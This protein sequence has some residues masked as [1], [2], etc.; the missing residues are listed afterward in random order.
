MLDATRKQAAADAAA[1]VAGIDIDDVK[2]GVEGH[3]G[4]AR[5]AADGEADDDAIVERDKDR[6]IGRTVVQPDA[7]PELPSIG[8]GEGLERPGGKDAGIGRLPGRRVDRRDSIDIIR[9]SRTN[10]AAFRM[11]KE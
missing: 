9:A 4:I 7:G 10:H 11:R 2:L 1:P 5:R 8:D 3:S 6:A